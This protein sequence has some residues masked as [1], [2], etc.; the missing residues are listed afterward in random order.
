METVQHEP[1]SYT[2]LIKIKEED[3]RK[4]FIDRIRK[5]Q[6]RKHRETM[7]KDAK[8][9]YPLAMSFFDR[10]IYLFNLANGTLNLR[11]LEFREHRAEDYLTKISPVVYD[12]EADCP[13]W[14]Q[15]MLSL[16]HISVRAD[17]PDFLRD[18]GK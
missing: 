15:F 17:E 11:T 8:S 3:T 12:P 14:T 13:R 5:L 6:Q 2:H 16:I 10:D 7:L 4:R 9:V 18:R 1:V